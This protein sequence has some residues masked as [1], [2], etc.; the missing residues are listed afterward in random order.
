[1]VSDSKT[2]CFDTYFVRETSP[3]AVIL[4]CL[5]NYYAMAKTKYDCIF[6]IHRMM[7]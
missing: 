2:L 3:A 7:S 5:D 6:K 4:E 1:M